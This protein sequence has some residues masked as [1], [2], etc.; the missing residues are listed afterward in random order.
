MGKKPI[1]TYQYSNNNNQSLIKNAWNIVIMQWE[2]NAWAYI[3]KTTQMQLDIENVARWIED[4]IED[5]LSTKSQQKWICRGVVEDLS[6]A[7]L[8]SM[9]WESVKNL[10]SKENDKKYGLM[11]Q[12]SCQKSN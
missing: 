10:S 11:D 6:T 4:S 3:T 5:L 1:Q 8:T 9:D 7:K 2:C 12:R